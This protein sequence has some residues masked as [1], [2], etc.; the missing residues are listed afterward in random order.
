MLFFIFVLS[1]M[2]A[3]KKKRKNL[4]YILWHV[5]HNPITIFYP[6]ETFFSNVAEINFPTHTHTRFLQI[7]Y[8]W[9]FPL[10]E[11]WHFVCA[12][13]LFRESLFASHLSET[14]LMLYAC[15]KIEREIRKQI[16]KRLL[17]SMKV[18]TSPSSSYTLTMSIY[19]IGMVYI[20][21]YQRYYGGGFFF[22]FLSIIMIFF[23][24][25]NCH[26]VDFAASSTNN[27]RH[28]E[29]LSHISRE[30]SVKSDQRI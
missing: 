29:I 21:A 16:W 23:L 17:P 7:F 8:A 22:F 13:L 26:N 19:H 1:W 3:K 20:N 10:C 6:S 25:E 9:S 4:F 28:D 15:K 12:A 30:Y 5:T 14:V 18:I 24:R 2:E 27:K 11:N